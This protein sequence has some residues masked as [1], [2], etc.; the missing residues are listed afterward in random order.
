MFVD[1][2][3]GL[4]L[5]A[6]LSEWNVG[7]QSMTQEQLPLLVKEL[8]EYNQQN[9]CFIYDRG[10]ISKQF[11]KLHKDLMVDFIFRLPGKCYLEI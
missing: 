10:Y 11:I 6:C 4:I 9:I 1:L 8:R 5:Y 2:C 3:T 7:E